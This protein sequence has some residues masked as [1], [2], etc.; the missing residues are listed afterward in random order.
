MRSS[1]TFNEDCNVG[2]R[3]AGGART[4]RAR[5]GSFDSSSIPVANTLPVTLVHQKL[6]TM[7]ARY[8]L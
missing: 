7:L 3:T 8:L 2:A 4:A 1:V 5:V 6:D